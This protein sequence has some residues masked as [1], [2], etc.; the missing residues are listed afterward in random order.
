MGVAQMATTSPPPEAREGFRLSV[1]IPAFDEEATLPEVLARLQRL[2]GPV[3][4]IV[5]ND[6]SRDGTA[7]WLADAERS[8]KLVVLHNETNCGKGASLRRGFAAATGPVVVIQDADLEYD[9]LEIERLVAPIEAGEADVVYGSRF[10]GGWSQANGPIHWAANRLL[11]TLSNWATGLRL[12]DM[13]T[14]QKAFRRDVLHS[15][16]LQENGFAIEPEITAA[17]ARAGWRVQEV[18]IRYAGR[19]KAGGKKIGF[20]DG[21]Y[22]IACILKSRMATSGHSRPPHD[23][24]RFRLGL[25]ELGLLLATMS[26]V[27]Q[28]LAPSV[29]SWW[30]R[31]RPGFQGELPAAGDRRLMDGTLP[32]RMLLYLPT[33]YSARGQPMP[34]LMHLH[35]SGAR[36]SDLALLRREGL[37]RLIHKG[38]ELPAVVASP[39]CQ[40]GQAW[41]SKQV[42]AVVDYLKDSY[43][44]DTR[45]IYL[46]GYS[47]GGYGTWRT[48][49]LYPQQFA[50][51]VPICGGGETEWATSLTG[52][53]IWAFHG[54]QDESVQVAET[55][56]MIDAIQLA[57][58]TPRL[59]VYPEGKHYIWDEVYRDNEVLEWLWQQRRMD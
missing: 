55:T 11:T 16:E 19:D 29:M 2:R 40:Q 33:G 21:L 58:G 18:P 31:P 47:M 39:Q 26:L 56:K 10:Q 13:E 6:G 32:Y 34:L 30:L 54:R 14:C 50:A 38:L 35:G 41:D 59:T 5:V 25:L 8:M 43:N 4:I 51:I 3:E 53:P 22:A 52:I 17:V 1:V 23:T 44:I 49:S 20:K 42:M 24:P 57:G 28:L 15:M 7:A 12:S 45:R 48:A 46:T 27:A 37:S 9:P 36:G